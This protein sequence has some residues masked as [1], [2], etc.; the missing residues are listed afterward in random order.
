[1]PRRTVG[2]TA[3]RHG[4]CRVPQHARTFCTSF[5]GGPRCGP[6]AP[7]TRGRADRP[8]ARTPSQKRAQSAKRRRPAVTSPAGGATDTLDRSYEHDVGT[9]H[10]VRK[11]PKNGSCCDRGIHRRRP[12]SCKCVDDR[13]TGTAYA[14]SAMAARCRATGSRKGNHDVG[15]K[16]GDTGRYD[17]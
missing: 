12:F 14:T 2:T 17:E 16:P 10:R 8:A 6:R 3:R 15:K 7:P 13:T 9:T 11:T 1:M 5:Q 4:L